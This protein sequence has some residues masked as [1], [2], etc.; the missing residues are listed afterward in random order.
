MKDINTETKLKELLKFTVKNNGV[1]SKEAI[2]INSAIKSKND[3]L[4]NT[5]IR[6]YMK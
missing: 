2:E 6:K 5:V 3:Y 4:R 1:F